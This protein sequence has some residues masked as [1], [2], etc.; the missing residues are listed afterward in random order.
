MTGRILV[1]LLLLAGSLS[2]QFG[3]MLPP[4]S[5]RVRVRIVFASGG[6][7]DSSINVTL[8]G[9]NGPVADGFVDRECVVELTSVP[10]GHYHITV[11][12]QSLLTSDTND[13][14]VDESD[15][16]DIEV[17]VQ[18][19]A[20]FNRGEA[21][22][23][24]MVATVDLKIPPKALREFD[25]ASRLIAKQDWPKAI[26]KLNRAIAI[27]PSYTAAYNNLGAVYGRLGDRARQRE[28]LRKA[29]SINDRYA[30]AYVN[31]SRASIAASDYPEAESLL[32]KAVALDPTD[33]MAIV[34][35]TYSEFM[36]HHLDQA[37]NHSRRAHAMPNSHHAIVH[38]V[39]SR[40]FA[41]KLQST[42]A[43]SELRL[44]LAE[45]QTGPRA[46]AA[47]KELASLQA[48]SHP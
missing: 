12:G 13:I 5:G 22:A 2:A 31:L 10:T 38:W 47:R 40:A 32:N 4:V 41:Q 15:T 46:D 19:T 37:I 35:L 16:R 28:S 42:Q 23:G 45:E 18:R 43:L 14:A 30:P 20:D 48:S 39:A 7:C 27:Y 11:S 26:E 34:L 6:V 3:N 29:I 9:T 8:L 24:P 25:Q 36:N 17:K 21:A 33:P 44:F 1:L